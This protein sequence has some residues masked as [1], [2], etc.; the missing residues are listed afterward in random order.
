M[1]VAQRKERERKARIDLIIRAAS[2][3][4]AKLGYHNTSMDLIAE[5]AELGKS[6]LYYY[7][8]SKEKLLVSVLE[9]GLKEFFNSLENNLAG[10]SDPLLKIETI[11][12]TGADFFSKNRNF[13]NLY[14]YLSAHPTLRK[15][16]YGKIQPIIAKKLGIIGSVLKEAKTK[17]LIKNLSLN[18]LTQIYGSLVMSMGIFLNPQT[19]KKQLEKRARLINEIFLTGIKSAGE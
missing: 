13:F 14:I 17:R 12:L 7:F 11:T 16:V 18:E 10:I 9:N 1:S 5:E 4:F 19:T 2:E 8:P 3:T 6:T 15:I